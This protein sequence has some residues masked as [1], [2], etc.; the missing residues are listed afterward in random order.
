MYFWG[1]YNGTNYGWNRNGKPLGL[2]DNQYIRFHWQGGIELTA[3]MLDYYD[4]TR[5]KNFRDSMLIPFADNIITF[6][7][8]HWPKKNGKIFFYPAMSLE[9]WWDCTN[10]MPEIA[11]LRYVLPRMIALDISPEKTRQWQKILTEIPPIPTVKVQGKEQLAPAQIYSNKRNIE[12]PELYAI[13]PYKHFGIGKPNLDIAINTWQHRKN[14]N[15]GGWNQNAIQ[16]ALLGQ[17]KQA[18]QFVT[19]NFS[20]KHK[21]SRFLAFWGPNYDWIPDQD[22]GSV[23]MNALQFM[24]IQTQ[25][26]KILLLPAWPN[27]WN[28]DF[29]LN[30]PK[31][32]TVAGSFK[33]GKITKLKVSPE[34]RRSDIKIFKPKSY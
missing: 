15:T 24:L 5:D 25:G 30:A 32:T 14:E 8:E 11:G 17:T 9:T 34:S 4:H 26:D 29:K 18:Q 20:T 13:F 3:M 28:V 12:H 2:T 19:K 33:N 22:H 23:A 10:P 6:F 27:E 16:A 1:T 7:A 21:T 31:N